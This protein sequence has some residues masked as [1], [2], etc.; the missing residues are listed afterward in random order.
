MSIQ[1]FKRHFRVDRMLYVI[2]IITLLW[3]L[4]TFLIVPMF[5]TFK[6][7]FFSDNQLRLVE[8]T[9]DLFGSKRVLFALKN[10]VWLTLFCTVT[11]GIVGIFQVLTLEYFY[12]RGR[13]LLKIGF[14]IPI[15]FGGVVAAAGYKF[16]YGPTGI[17]TLIAQ[18][19][20]PNLSD[21]WFIGGWGVLYSQTFLLTGFYFLFM[22][23]AMRKVD[24]STIEA[25]RSMGASEF[26]VLRR[27]VFPVLL[28]SLLAVIL[29]TMYVT[30]SS[31]AVAEIIGGRKFI[32]IS[33][34]I[35]TLNA[36][37][38]P[39]MAAYLATLMGLF[40]MMMILLMQWAEA[41]GSYSGGAKTTVPIELKRVKNPIANVVLHVTT[42]ALLIIYATPVV[43][44]ILF[45]F[46]PGSSIGTEIFPSSF[47]FSNYRK[48]L[49]GGVASEPFYNSFKMVS[50]AVVAGLCTTLFAVSVIDKQKNI[51]GR[52]LDIG[53][54][55]PWLVPSVLLAIG[56][57]VTFDTPNPLVGNYV[58]LGSF[59]I[60]PIAYIVSYLPHMV[61]FVRAAF[62]G[63]DPSL[64][65]AARALGAKSF[66]R[67]RRVKLPLLFP[68]VMLAGG[69]VFNELLSEYPLS[70]FLYNVNNK[71]L[72]IAIVQSD[73]NQ[74]PE[75]AAISLV[76]AVL[77]M[78]FTLAVLL[79][80]ERLSLGK[81]PKLNN[82]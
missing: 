58:L 8:V 45:S 76:Y 52:I 44:V 39:D 3:F 78:C 7:A 41:K 26:T 77:I 15:V 11:V 20:L 14:A 51:F 4:A 80:A 82:L 17:L 33:Q 37:G 47:T 10:T 6:T 59:M 22:R 53:F 65:E 74:D 9:R 50:F 18:S 71:P 13:A 34:M 28:P 21:D 66:Y 57:I 81:G 25:A 23:A 48:V 79:V 31:F 67:F 49:F 27:V 35:I 60:V 5:Y 19:V 54:F 43:L 55:L 1:P 69:Y 62:M 16:T 40:I 36:I 64:D 2:G 75:Q 63:I 61:R 68:T 42:Y 12:V 73:L 29:L 30:I 32:V 56:Y 72:S 70:A 46:A 38:R 24:Y